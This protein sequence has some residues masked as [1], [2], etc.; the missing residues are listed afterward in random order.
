MTSLTAQIMKRVLLLHYNDQNFSPHVLD[1]I[2]HFL[3]NDDI[4][5]NPL[6]HQDLIREMKLEAILVTENS[7]SRRGPLGRR[8]HRRPVHA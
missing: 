3:G 8:K 1:Q 2:Q 6:K 7:P 5:E 4:V